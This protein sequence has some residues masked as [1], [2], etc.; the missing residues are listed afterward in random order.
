MG[1][2]LPVRTTRP[3][4]AAGGTGERQEQRTPKPS[5]PYVGRG[6]RTR[7]TLPLGCLGRCNSRELDGKQALLLQQACDKGEHLIHS[8]R[9]GSQCSS[10]PAGPPTPHPTPR[11]LRVQSWCGTGLSSGWGRGTCL[12]HSAAPHHTNAARPWP[13][14]GSWAL[15]SSAIVS[16]NPKRPKTRI[17]YAR[18]KTF[19]EIKYVFLNTKQTNK[20]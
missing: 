16:G 14:A 19:L 18:P 3:V 7:A 12:T 6:P 1:E 8:H 20:N 11:V 15:F 4:R 10:C 5:R 9:A 2:R 17:H 13:E